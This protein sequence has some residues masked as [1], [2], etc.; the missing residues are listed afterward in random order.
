MLFHNP[1]T[2]LQMLF[3]SL[4]S[5]PC[6]PCSYLQ[7]QLMYH[8][9]LKPSLTFFLPILSNWEIKG[10]VSAQVTRVQKERKARWAS[11]TIRKR[12]INAAR[13]FS[14]HHYFPAFSPLHPAFSEFQLPSLR[15]AITTKLE[16]LL[17][18]APS[19]SHQRGTETCSPWPHT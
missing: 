7:I 4:T 6:N 19:L 9:L 16:L 13:M 14:Y 10:N 15:P 12:D 5:L 11:G 3:P 2:F 18:A 1:P 17:L 8:H